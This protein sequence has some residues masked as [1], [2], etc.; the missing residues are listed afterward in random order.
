MQ[1]L[2]VTIVLESSLTVLESSTIQ[3]LLVTMPIRELSNSVLTSKNVITELSNS[4]LTSKKSSYRAP[5]L[6]SY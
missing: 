2:L 6:H 4:I 1:F 3:F 5:Q